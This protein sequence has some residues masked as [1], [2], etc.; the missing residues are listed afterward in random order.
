MS[1]VCPVVGVDAGAAG[2]GVAHCGRGGASVWTG[3]H[4]GRK[5]DSALPGRMQSELVPAAGCT[6]GADGWGW[7]GAEIQEAHSWS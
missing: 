3:R 4:P 5:A 7:G 2:G 1:S 6:V